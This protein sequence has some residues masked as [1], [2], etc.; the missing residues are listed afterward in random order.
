MI[1]NDILFR[2]AI[3]T[4]VVLSAFSVNAIIRLSLIGIV[5]ASIQCLGLILIPALSPFLASIAVVANVF[6]QCSE[7]VLMIFVLSVG[8]LVVLIGI[9]AQVS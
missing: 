1:G 6:S 2:F 7:T 5:F 4:S 3:A 8:S 9:S